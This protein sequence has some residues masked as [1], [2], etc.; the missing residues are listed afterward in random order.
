MDNN[1]KR[2]REWVKWSAMG[3]HAVVRGHGDKSCPLFSYNSLLVVRSRQLQLVTA[4]YK[5][6]GVD[7]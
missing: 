6:V 4:E 5:L 3:S 7:G 2:E 1:N